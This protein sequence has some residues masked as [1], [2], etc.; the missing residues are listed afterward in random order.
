M[1]NYKDS[2]PQDFMWDYQKSP[3]YKCGGWT[4]RQ[5]REECSAITFDLLTTPSYGHVFLV[6][7]AESGMKQFFSFNTGDATAQLEGTPPYGQI[8]WHYKASLQEYLGSRQNTGRLNLFFWNEVQRY[9]ISLFLFLSLALLF[10]PSLS[11]DYKH[12]LVFIFA[13][14]LVNA[15]VC[16]TLSTVADRF[17][18]RVVW[19]LPLPLFLIMANREFLF[20]KIKRYFPRKP[21]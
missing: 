6:K 12:I 10:Y 5:V 8:H 17:Q 4:S 21:D 19:L 14:L 1:C 15:F 13:G 3:F 11:V 7:A 20:D 2:I 18:S 9:T 16:G